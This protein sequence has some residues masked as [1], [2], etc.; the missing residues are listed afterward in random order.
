MAAVERLSDRDLS[1]R[2]GDGE[3]TR[4]DILAHLADCYDE[5]ATRLRLISEGRRGEIR[6]FGASQVDAKNAE[7]QVQDALLTPA[8][9]RRRL[10]SAHDA[11]QRRLAR[12]SDE[13]VSAGGEWSVV[14][15]LP[16]WTWEHVAEH[17][18][19]LESSPH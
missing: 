17:L 8:E 4:R 7:R 13:Q 18:A 9:V 1:A 14:A 5:A 6:W 19:D 10:T 16:G 2:R 3:W 11:L 12:L 15:W